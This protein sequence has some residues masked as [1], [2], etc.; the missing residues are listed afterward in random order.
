MASGTSSASK[1]K[2]S[3]PSVFSSVTLLPLTGVVVV[4]KLSDV[5]V[6]EEQP[7]NKTVTRTSERTF[8][9]IL[10]FTFIFFTFSFFFL[11]SQAQTR[12]CSVY[13]IMSVSPYQR[14][15]SNNYHIFD[16]LNPLFFRPLL[17][18]FLRNLLH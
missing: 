2:F 11:Y 6:S 16:I 15:K 14:N 13:S 18:L 1:T 10:L 17:F 4:E 8:N 3:E 7:T 5:V 12:Y 9:D